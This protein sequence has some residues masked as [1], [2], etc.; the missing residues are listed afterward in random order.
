MRSDA[1]LGKLLWGSYT[2]YEG[3]LFWGRFKYTIRENPDFWEKALATVTATEG[4]AYDGI[5][6]YDRCIL[7]VGIIQWGDD[8]AK[9]SVVS[10]LG[11]CAEVN[12]DLLME[13]LRELPGPV[14]LQRNA[15]GQWQLLYKGSPV[16]NSTTRRALYLGGSTGLKGQW[17]SA[18]KAHARRVAAVMA[19]L[20]ENDC[21]RDVQ[22]EFTKPKLGS[23]ALQT[24]QKEL[25]GSNLIEAGWEGAL[26]AAYISFA[27]NLP[28]V[29][30]SQ[31][32]YAMTQPEWIEGD[33]QDKCHALLKAMTFRPRI[34]I[35]LHRYDKI[36]PVLE[37]QFG[38]DLPDFS[39]ELAKWAADM[40]EGS[41]SLKNPQDLQRALIR[42]GY[43]LGPA[44]ADGR[45]GP[46]TKEAIMSFQSSK[47]LKPD[48]IVGPRT[49]AA[50]LKELSF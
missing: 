20:W 15:Q 11:Q 18:Q 37:E 33:P 7:T 21:F 38:V 36:R 24:A 1:V 17:T 35:Y 26:R 14:G 39:H 29:A 46:K 4:A 19:S 23:F 31:L 9:G 10:M 22:L 30:S 16:V 47:S 43:D 2:T 6:M 13:Y 28:A 32:Q 42:L 34:P 45:I 8:C 41:L 49:T 27:A 3:P 12:H 5:N 48:G 40:P 25:F 50:L 44:G